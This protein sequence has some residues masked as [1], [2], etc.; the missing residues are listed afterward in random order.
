MFLLPGY[1]AVRTTALARDSVVARMAKLV[2]DAHKKKSQTERF[3]DKCAKYY[4]PCKSLL[5]PLINVSF[6]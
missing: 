1:I 3:I 5:N 2:E 4:I 6:K